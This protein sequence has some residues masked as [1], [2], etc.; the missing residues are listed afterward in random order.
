MSKIIGAIKSAVS[1]VRRF[2][3]GD[4]A[5]AAVAQAVAM[6]KQALPIVEAIALLTP[7]RADDE[8]VAL[9]KAY[10]LPAVE[11]WLELPADRRGAALFEAASQL[12]ARQFPGVLMNIINTSVQMAYTAWRAEQK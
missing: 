4:R 3:A 9:F 6:V 1:A 12:L 5:K 2:V 11:K 10:G 8:I 7:T